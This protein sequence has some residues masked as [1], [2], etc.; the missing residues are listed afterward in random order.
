LAIFDEKL[1]LKLKLKIKIKNFDNIE[2]L[3]P[4]PAPM[5]TGHLFSPLIR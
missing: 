1:E 2:I 4:N 5:A 3:L